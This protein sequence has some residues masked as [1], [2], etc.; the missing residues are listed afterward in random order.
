MNTGLFY[1]FQSYLDIADNYKQTPG[2]YFL[3]KN[4]AINKITFF[5]SKNQNILNP[6]EKTFLN[7][8]IDKFRSE[9]KNTINANALT[10]EEYSNFLEHYFDKIDFNQ[11]NNRQLEICKDLCEVMCEFG[12]LEELWVK[13]SNILSFLLFS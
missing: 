5:L 12:N 1:Q 4:Y 8:A 3:I 2:L 9:V 10:K 7:N 6:N 11:A 13:R